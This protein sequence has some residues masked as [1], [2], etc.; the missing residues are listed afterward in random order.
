MK[1][2]R[3]ESDFMTERRYTHGQ[4]PGHSKVHDGK[5]AVGTSEWSGNKTMA[6]A[7]PFYMLIPS[8]SNIVVL[9]RG[10]LTKVKVHM[11][12]SMQQSNYIE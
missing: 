1:S 4:F 11:S 10:H 5:Y 6:T 7:S 12:H 9:R 8:L 2:K 3:K